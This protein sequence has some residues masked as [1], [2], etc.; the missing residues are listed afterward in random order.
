MRPTSLHLEELGFFSK[1]WWDL[2]PG[3]KFIITDD[4]SVKVIYEGPLISFTLGTFPT[5][6]QAEVALTQ[7]E[8]LLAI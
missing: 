7:L 3:Y 4:Y 6:Y 5:H 1:I 2:G 8:L